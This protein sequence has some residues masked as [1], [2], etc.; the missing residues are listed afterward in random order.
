MS[1]FS[2][3]EPV[4][5]GYFADPF[6]LRAGG[7]LFAFGTDAPGNPTFSKTGRMF[8]V[9]RSQDGLRW[10][11]V[12]GALT[13]GPNMEGCSFWAPEAAEKDGRFYLYYSA[14]DEEG[15]GHQLRVA[16]SDR[17]EGPYEDAGVILVPD[18]P[19]SIDA[20]PFCDP[21][22]GRWRLLFAKDFFDG[23]AGTGLAL[24]SL[25][26]DMVCL[27]DAEVT[28]ILRATSDW[29]IY[30]RDRRWYDRDWQAWH[31]VEGPSLAMCDGR[32]YLFYSG[33]LW[34]SANYGIGV[35]V[36]DRVQGPYV[37]PAVEAGPSL[38]KSGDFDL[39]GPG[40]NSL[41]VGADSELWI[42]FHAWSADGSMRRMHV[43]PLT[44]KDGWP[45]ISS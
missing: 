37:D 5:D 9:L 24:V 44:W 34:K 17:P 3:K 14:G 45:R 15:R 28:T 4:W 32:Y 41:F 19:F 31:T 10:D 23:R 38:L 36:A 33:G 13:P 12:G 6:V 21:L 40:H 7:E 25:A 1:D 29:Q 42:A 26:P 30:E 20:H 39:I 2:I 11:W 8:P 22:D 27:A 16:V 43:A 35:A 18:E